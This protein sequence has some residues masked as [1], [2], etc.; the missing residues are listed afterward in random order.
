ME[1]SIG[2]S[3]I[4]QTDFGDSSQ[5]CAAC[6]KSPFTPTEG[7]TESVT[8]SLVFA[9]KSVAD[10]AKNSMDHPLENRQFSISLS[11]LE[12][13]GVNIILVEWKLTELRTMVTA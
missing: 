1:I 12:S 7:E 2:S 10:V 6:G 9:V 4:T 5:Y 8:F 11:H 13:H 3:R